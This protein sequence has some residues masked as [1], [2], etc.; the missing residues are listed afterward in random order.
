MAYV[1]YLPTLIGIASGKTIG[2][3]SFV[4]FIFY[5]SMKHQVLCKHDVFNEICMTVTLHDGRGA[6]IANTLCGLPAKKT[7]LM[8]K[9]M[10]SCLY[11]WL[12]KSRQNGLRQ[13][14]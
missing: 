8:G 12:F 4:A 11:F 14:H 10:I 7:S 1:I 9:E 13:S 6:V 5:C 2:L 3:V